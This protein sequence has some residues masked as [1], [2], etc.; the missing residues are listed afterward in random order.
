MFGTN[1]FHLSLAEALVKGGKQR[2]QPPM[3]ILRE[4]LSFV[5]IST[6]RDKVISEIETLVHIQLTF[7]FLK[8]QLLHRH[9]IRVLHWFYIQVSIWKSI[10]TVKLCLLCCANQITVNS[11]S[12]LILYVRSTR[13][14]STKLIPSLHWSAAIN[15]FSLLGTLIRRTKLHLFVRSCYKAQASPPFYWEAESDKLHLSNYY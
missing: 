3:W 8:K 10:R 14:C 9:I 7:M 1:A 11:A 2:V 4:T 12:Q 13:G 15:G 5:A 6:N